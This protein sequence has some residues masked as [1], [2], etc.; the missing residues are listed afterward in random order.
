LFLGGGVSSA[1]AWAAQVLASGRRERVA[2]VLNRLLGI[3]RE[4]RMATSPAALDALSVEIDTLVMETI[5]HTQSGATDPTTMS[6]LMLAI[7]AARAALSD[8]RAVL[9]QSDPRSVL[10]QPPPARSA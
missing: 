3:L 4:A 2:N 9:S 10:S 1:A 8:Q 5:S 6:A 7:D